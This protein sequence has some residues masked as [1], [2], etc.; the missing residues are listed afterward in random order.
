[1]TRVPRGVTALFALATLFAVPARAELLNPDN[2]IVKAGVSMP[3]N[4]LPKEARRSWF[5]GG[6]EYQ[7][8]NPNAPRVSSVE[9]L[10]TGVD[11]HISPLFQEPVSVNYKMLS[12]MLNQRF[13]KAPMGEQTIGNILF[14]GGGLGIQTIWA[15]IQDPNPASTIAFDDK[16]TFAGANLFIGYEVAANLEIQAKY[17]TVFGK[18]NGERMDT[19]QLLAGL[20]L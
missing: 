20:R 18:V 11:E 12:L 8:E 3:T 13:R 1:M 5:A 15:D 17:Q 2:W 16:R 19:I 7:I 14:Y 10:Y 9:L 4:D 6:L